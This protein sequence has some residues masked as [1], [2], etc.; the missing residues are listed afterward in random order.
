M[1]DSKALIL[2][3]SYLKDVHYKEPERAQNL[4]NRTVKA[5]KNAFDKAI[6]DKRGWIWIE[7]E[8]IH[9]LLRVKTKADARYYLQS[10]PKKDEISINGKQYIRGFVFISFI[11]KF[12][13]EKGNNKYLPIVNEYYN[14]INTSNDVKLVRLEFDNYLKAQKRKLKSKR[15]KKYNIKE[16]ELTGKNIDIRTCEFSHIR[17]VS[18]YQEYSDNIENGLIVNKETHDKITRKEIN[19]ED[20]LYDLCIDNGWNLQWYEKYKKHLNKW[21]SY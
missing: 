19:D 12:M 14:L 13:E 7:E 18:M 4:N 2:V 21:T 10:V 16:D 3:K 17:S 9:S 6:L 15:I 20:E 5:I 1:D 11:N 8:S